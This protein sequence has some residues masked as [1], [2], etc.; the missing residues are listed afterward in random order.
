VLDS[1]RWHR[2][3]VALRNTRARF[4]R[5]HPLLVFEAVLKSA[6]TPALRARLPRRPF[7]F[8][9]RQPT[10]ERVEAGRTYELRLVFPDADS[11]EVAA[12]GSA[13]EAH[14]ANPRNNFELARAEKP[15]ECSLAV[16]QGEHG[17]A[18]LSDE[19]CLEFVTPL[20][21]KP[22]DPARKWTYSAAELGTTLSAHLTALLGIPP[23]PH[24]AAWERLVTLPWFW[25]FESFSHLSNS[26][27]RQVLLRGNAGPLFLRGELGPVWPLLLLGSEFHAQARRGCQGAFQLRPARSVFNA[28]LRDPSTYLGA[29]H[30]WQRDDDPPD[31]SLPALEQPEELASMLARQ[32]GERAF[33]PSP[34]RGFGIAKR[35]GETRLLAQLTARDHV[36]HKALLHELS[37]AMDRMLHTSAVAFRRGSSPDAARERLREALG[38][39]HT[40]AVRADLQRFFDEVD[41]G[42]LAA[43]LGDAFPRADTPLVELLMTLART[44]VEIGGRILERDRGLLQGSPLSPLLSNLYLNDLD[45]EL[46][47]RGLFHLRYGDDLLLLARS[48]DEA[49]AALATLRQ[50]AAGVRLSLNPD[51]TAVVPA[52]DELLWLGQTIGGDLDPVHI[53]EAGMRRSLYITR[54]SSWAGVDGEALIV[55][56]RDEPGVSVPLRQLD[57]VVLMGAGGA[58]AKLVERLRDFDVP[59]TFATPLGAPINTLLPRNRSQSDTLARHAARFESASPAER[60]DVA[61]RLVRA[62]LHN[63]VVWL[64]DA[65]GPAAR[66]AR[67]SLRETLARLDDVRDVDAL[68]GHE[69]AA[70]RVMF[71]YCNDRAGAGWF[72]PARE[73]HTRRD[74]WNSLLDLASHL[75]FS[76]LLILCQHHGLHPWLGFLHSPHNRYESLVCDLQEPFRARLERFILRLVIRKVIQ[77][78]EFDAH[79][80]GGVRLTRAATIQFLEQW[81]RELLSTFRGDPAHLRTLLTAQVLE[82]RAWA[83]KPERQIGI[84]Q[85]AQRPHKKEPP[86]PDSPGETDKDEEAE[87]DA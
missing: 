63:G 84:F 72:S 9:P 24:D 68:R 48:E 62:K 81:E 21:Y 18:P 13:L 73:P 77:L 47:S 41:W 67:D 32:V 74:P 42:R 27:G 46:E 1:L 78:R 70:A 35:S 12:F 40:W 50:L 87:S 37:P 57:A 54:P 59:L 8:H 5:D 75:L 49:H 80:A 56:E 79:P 64:E 43:K 25:H 52:N 69:G 58:S 29:I 26:T 11:A 10:G 3:D 85:S 33:A 44:P 55:R 20:E 76:R 34:A 53:A 2:L 86:H 30:A 23:V 83:T 16:L 51:K 38:G 45:R 65:T 39:G 60:L 66:Q 14:L 6:L 17:P 82:V 7:L 36:L 15:V 4:V 28:T 22:R 71:R 19:V 31:D 61:R